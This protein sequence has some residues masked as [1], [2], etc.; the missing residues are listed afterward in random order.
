MG[1]TDQVVPVC[2]W[3]VSTPLKTSSVTVKQVDGSFGSW[4]SANFCSRACLVSFI[5]AMSA[6]TIWV[7]TISKVC[8][9]AARPGRAWCSIAWQCANKTS[10]AGGAVILLSTRGLPISRW[11]GNGVPILLPSTNSIVVHLLLIHSDELLLDTKFPKLVSM[12][13]HENSS[14][15]TS[16]VRRKIKLQLVTSLASSSSSTTGRTT[17]K[18]TCSAWFWAM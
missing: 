5:C 2:L 16:A 9:G 11:F 18:S 4:S 1:S 17:G 15:G 7:S 13:N 12:S 10:S 6:V 14:K 3:F 8:G